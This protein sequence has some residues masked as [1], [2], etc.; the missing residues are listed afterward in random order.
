M[1][2]ASSTTPRETMP[3][4]AAGAWIGAGLLLLAG[5]AKL[6]RPDTSTHALVLAGLPGGRGA[7][8]TLGAGELVLAATALVVGGPVW[9]VQAVAYAGF[10]AFVV[11]QRAQPTSSCGCFGEE[12]V[13]VTALHVAVDAALALAAVVAAVVGVPGLVATVTGPLGWLVLPLVGVATLVVRMVL[14]D[15]PVLSDAI[16]TAEAAS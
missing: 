10:T 4:A 5:L 7:V 11:R 8:R 12:E 6:R 3:L 2:G 13:P 9:G 15:L 14:V 1:L 16:R